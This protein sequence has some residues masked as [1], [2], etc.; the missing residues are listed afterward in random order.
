M[1]MIG[2]T[3]DDGTVVRFEFEPDSG[4]RPVGPDEIV[5][6]LRDAVGPAVEAARA[7]LARVRE[8]G[9]DEIAVTFGIKVTGTM[10]WL[11]AKAASEANFEVTL[12]WKARAE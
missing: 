12:S 8:V 4:F 1:A 2:Y 11:V 7:V 6:K 9:P 10:N 5:G 3:L